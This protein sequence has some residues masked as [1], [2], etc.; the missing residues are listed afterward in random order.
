[1]KWEIRVLT[2]DSNEGIDLADFNQ[3][4]LID[5]AAGRNWYAAPD[6]TPRPVRTIEDW[7]G[8]VLSNG[9]HAIDLNADGWPDLI[10]GSFNLPEVYW[11]ENPRQPSLNQGKMWNKHLLMDTGASENE[12]QL[13][14]DVDGDGIPEWI[15]SSWNA[16]TPLLVWRFRQWPVVTT[17]GPDSDASATHQGAM[18]RIVIGEELNGHGLGLGDLNGDGR[19][20]ILFESG[21]YEAPSSDPF[22]RPWKLHADWKVHASL[23]ILVRDL[24]RDGRADLVIGRAHDYGLYW[25]EQE[26]P[27]PEG[28]LNWT[29]HLIDDSFSQPHSL[30]WADLDGD[31][32]D[33]LITGKR[34]YA[35]NGNDPGGEEPP[36]I[37]YFKWRED[38]R[39]FD[40]Y[41]ID[42]GRVGGGLQIR[43][44]DLNNDQRLD[45]AV[46]GKSGTYLLFNLGR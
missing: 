28:K 31:G 40:K 2:I 34:V 9:D 11:Y 10:S 45:I 16:E 32:D 21:W 22:H 1:L 6:F 38:M 43:T 7:S 30:H 19:D 4:G 44:A 18:E 17:Q 37:Y 33:E 46:A 24:T 5:V 25:W 3:D 8:Y 41:V 26:P 13:L 20:D 27:S 39:R 14:K 35:H 36:C 15:V 42:E 29:E 12:G 23:P